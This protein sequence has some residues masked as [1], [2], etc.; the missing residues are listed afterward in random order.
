MP[1]LQG[2]QQKEGVSETE[3]LP[4]FAP[5]ISEETL[6]ELN[7]RVSEASWCVVVMPTSHL[8]FSVRH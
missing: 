5:F 1:V 7:P 6:S 2:S 8:G 3:K 4:V